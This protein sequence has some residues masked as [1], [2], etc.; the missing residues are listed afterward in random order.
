MFPPRPIELEMDV[1]DACLIKQQ[2]YRMAL[3]THEH[4]DAEVKYMIQK[5]IVVPSSSQP[6]TKKGMQRFLG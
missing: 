1:G 5:N 4:L 6:T 3:G 2:Y